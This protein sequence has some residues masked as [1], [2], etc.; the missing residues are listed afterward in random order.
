[1]KCRMNLVCAVA[2]LLLAACPVLG[3][4]KLPYYPIPGSPGY[5]NP[6]YPPTYPFPPGYPVMSQPVPAPDPDD[7]RVKEQLIRVEAELWANA[8]PS[9]EKALTVLRA[10]R[11]N[12]STARATPWWLRP[13][14]KRTRRPSP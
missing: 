9:V 14:K 6:G 5:P 13:P 8:F 7:K 10:A 2:V 1:M 4:I 12:S 3:M 11:T